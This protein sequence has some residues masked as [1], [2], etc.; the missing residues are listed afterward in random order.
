MGREGYGLQ[1][2]SGKMNE[3]E[4]ESVAQSKI[5]PYPTPPEREKSK[6]KELLL[7]K[8]PNLQD[9]EKLR[10]ERGIFVDTFDGHR[11]LSYKDHAVLPGD[12]CLSANYAISIPKIDKLTKLFCGLSGS[13]S[14]SGLERIINYVAAVNSEITPCYDALDAVEQKLD[15]SDKLDIANVMFEYYDMKIVSL[16]DV[17][18]GRLPSVCFERAV[19]LASVLFLDKNLHDLGIKSYV[20]YGKLFNSGEPVAN[21]AWVKL[22]VPT[23]LE[24]LGFEHQAYVLDP[25]S[26]KVYILSENLDEAGIKYIEGKDEPFWVGI[27]R[28]PLSKNK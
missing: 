7:S 17:L 13:V 26:N 22:M 1:V 25:T 2:V 3:A 6:Y 16:E 18:S 15:I 28:P 5:C 14:G 10:P 23:G 11:R 9:F 21:H 24:A 12:F 27:L 4:A 20:S 19:A 8:Y